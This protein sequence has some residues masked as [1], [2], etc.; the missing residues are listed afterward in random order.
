MPPGVRTTPTPGAGAWGSRKAPAFHTLT[1]PQ[2]SASG[3]ARVLCLCVPLRPSRRLSRPLGRRTRTA[4]GRSVGAPRRV[5]RSLTPPSAPASIGCTRDDCQ[6]CSRSQRASRPCSRAPARQARRPAGDRPA[7]SRRW[8]VRISSTARRAHARAA[9]ARP[10]LSGGVG[11][12]STPRAPHRL[13]HHAQ[14]ICITRDAVLDGS[15]G[16]R[17]RPIL[18]P[19]ARPDHVGVEVVRDASAASRRM[20]KAPPDASSG[21]TLSPK[22]VGAIG[23]RLPQHE[24][25]PERQAERGDE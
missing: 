17:V 13:A 24:K 21:A 19:L 2:S 25:R 1:A 3:A 6:Q 20:K 15:A 10:D 4:M 14:P 22:A 16:F 5:S 8:G 9:R 11:F 23:C 12:A 7:A 18:R